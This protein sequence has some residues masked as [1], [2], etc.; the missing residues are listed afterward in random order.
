MIAFIEDATCIATLLWKVN[1]SMEYDPSKVSAHMWSPDFTSINLILILILSLIFWTLPTSKK[2]TFSSL[3]IIWISFSEYLYFSHDC[4]ALT[5]RESIPSKCVK[6]SSHILLQRY[7]LSGSG[8]SFRNGNTAIDLLCVANCW[9]F[10]NSFVRN[11]E[12]ID[13]ASTTMISPKMNG[14]CFQTG[15]FFPQNSS[16]HFTSSGA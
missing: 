12:I 10:W 11:I 4:L 8:L 1:I 3:P 7:S 9:D 13:I 5:C 2:A 15:I 14:F 16:V 6:I